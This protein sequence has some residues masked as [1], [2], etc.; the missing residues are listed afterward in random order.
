MR[1]TID[2]NIRYLDQRLSVFPSR[3]AVGE[4]TDHLVVE[5][6]FPF[7]ERSRIRGELGGFPLRSSRS[8]KYVNGVKLILGNL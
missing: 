3:A 6:K 5:F 2:R 1:V 7:T 8:S 4:E